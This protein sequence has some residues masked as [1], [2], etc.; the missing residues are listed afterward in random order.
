MNANAREQEIFAE[1]RQKQEPTIQ[2]FIDG[3]DGHDWDEQECQGG[4]L[5]T[6]W[7]C[8]DNLWVN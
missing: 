2:A 4:T 1:T 6:C 5:F 7:D 3:H 8:D